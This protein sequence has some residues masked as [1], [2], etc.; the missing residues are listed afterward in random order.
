MAKERNLSITNLSFQN[1]SLKMNKICEIILI[2]ID[3]HNVGMKQ[4][5]FA[6]TA[7]N[8]VHS[9]NKEPKARK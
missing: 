2:D 8:P 1:H 9:R 4:S 5:A 7:S 3:Q 6:I